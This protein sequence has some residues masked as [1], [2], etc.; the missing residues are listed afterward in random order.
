MAPV[1][2]ALQAMCG[3]GIMTATTVA[4]E[5]GDLEKKQPPQPVMKAEAVKRKVSTDE[6][7]K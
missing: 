3:V 1:V 2:A 5:A 6:R 4:A 7:T